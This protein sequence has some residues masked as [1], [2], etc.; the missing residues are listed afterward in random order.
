MK[1]KTY[2]CDSCKKTTTDPYG[3]YM[4]EFFV[5]TRYGKLSTFYENKRRLRKVC[6]CSTCFNA[7]NIIANQIEGVK[8]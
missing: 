1:R 6:L 8:V 3:D 4:R 2:I 7:L 5:K